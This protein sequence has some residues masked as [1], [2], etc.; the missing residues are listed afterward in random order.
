MVV[1]DQVSPLPGWQEG[2]IMSSLHVVAMV[3]DK[4]L[5]AVASDVRR[6]A[7]APSS[8]DLSDY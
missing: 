5:R 7:Q 1:G 3:A 2:A 4:R 8:R 6:P